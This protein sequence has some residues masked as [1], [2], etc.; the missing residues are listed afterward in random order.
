MMFGIGP[1]ARV[2]TKLLKVVLAFI[3]RSFDTDIAGYI[4]DFL[5]M[6]STFSECLLQAQQV[7]L[8][9]QGLGFSVNFKKSLLTP[10]RQVEHLGFI[11]N[12]ETMTVSLPEQKISKITESATKFLTEGAV[13]TNSLRSF[14]G[15]LESI[16]LV[17]EQGPLH[18][19][20]L[21]RLIPH[22]EPD[23]ARGSFLSRIPAR[24]TSSGGKPRS[25]T[26]LTPRPPSGGLSPTCPSGPTPR[27]TSVGG[28]TTSQT[29]YK[30]SGARTRWITT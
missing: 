19:R 9:F 7:I 27:G 11:W 16:R 21:Q 22:Q 3:R 8:V 4:D 12:S 28:D 2:F 29:S 17:T 15:R 30:G 1:S 25:H 13:P 5:I 24:E 14:L 20:N 26:L 18:Y 23:K 6:T 10:S